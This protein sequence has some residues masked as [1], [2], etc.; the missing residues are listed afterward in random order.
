M[1]KGLSCVGDYRQDDTTY[2]MLENLEYS[3]L[4]VENY[5]AWALRPETPIT[6]VSLYLLSKPFVEWL[7]VRLG[8]IT[9]VKERI[10]SSANDTILY[11]HSSII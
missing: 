1:H 3:T 10:K 5:F 4:S 6:L 2:T 7:R 9:E 8:L 11:C